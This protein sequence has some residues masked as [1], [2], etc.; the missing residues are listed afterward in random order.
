MSAE[1]RG[2]ILEAARRAFASSGYQRSSNKEIAA[3]AEVTAP[4]LYH[5]FDSKAAL[6]AAVLDQSVEILMAAYLAASA[7]ATTCLDRLCSVFEANVALNRDHPGLAEFLAH[8]PLEMKRI[9]ELAR[10]S[11][12][13]GDP[14]S[15]LFRGWLEAGV[16]EGELS[17]QLDVESTVRLLTALAFGLSWFH[18]LVPTP[19]DHDDMLRLCQRMLRG[20]IFQDS[21]G[22]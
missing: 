8:A 6:F 7:K 15:A 13:V 10:A 9:P 19:A 12:A 5:W 3:A 14:L 11:G 20:E 18:G 4:A 16:G 21:A 17:P 2:R 1:T 22:E